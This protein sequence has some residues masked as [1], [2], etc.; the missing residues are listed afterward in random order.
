MPHWESLMDKKYLRWFHLRS[1]LLIEID[2]VKKGEVLKLRGGG[3]K[4]GSVITYKVIK[5]AVEQP[6]PLV[7]NYTNAKTI[8]E[9]VDEDYDRWIG[10]QVVLYVDETKMYSEEKKRMVLSPCIRIR[11]PKTKAKKNESKKGNG[12]TGGA[13]SSADNAGGS[14]HGQEVN[15]PGGEESGEQA[16]VET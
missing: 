14:E 12:S 11:A 2:S 6:L 4:I 13:N 3:E 8:S 1:P 9:V 16:A 5:G 10:G 7:L 15:G